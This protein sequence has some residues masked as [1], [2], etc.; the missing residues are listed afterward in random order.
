MKFPSI[1]IKCRTRLGWPPGA[2]TNRCSSELPLDGRSKVATP[3]SFGSLR[4]SF[5]SPRFLIDIGVIWMKGST[6]V[7]MVLISP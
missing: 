7:R 5:E 3:M 4:L 6:L 2:A 1:P